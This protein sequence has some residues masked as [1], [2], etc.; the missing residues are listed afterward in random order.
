MRSDYVCVVHSVLEFTQ[1][2]YLLL[3]NGAF[4]EYNV[5]DPFF[6]NKQIYKAMDEC[7]SIILV[8]TNIHK[9]QPTYWTTKINKVYNPELRVSK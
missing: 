5:I 2:Y 3:S 4:E 6:L 1:K 9:I 8:K 7:F